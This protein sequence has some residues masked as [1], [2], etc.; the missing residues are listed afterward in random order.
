MIQTEAAG[1]AEVYVDPPLVLE[2]AQRLHWASDDLVLA[3]IRIDDACA[4]AHVA[5]VGGDRLQRVAA[6]AGES[7]LEMRRRIEHYLASVGRD[8]C[9]AG[10]VPLPAVGPS[11]AT[12]GLSDAVPHPTPGVA[13][14]PPGGPDA[15]S[16]VE[17]VDYRSDC[18]VVDHGDEALA[19]LGMIP[20]VGS[21]FDAG[22][23]VAKLVQGKW[24]DA[25]LYLAA[26]VPGPGDI[27]DL[28]LKESEQERLAALEDRL[29][30]AS[31][32]PDEAYDVL[33]FIESHNGTPPR[34]YAGGGAWRNDLG[35]LP[36]GDYRKYD[37]DV[38]VD[39]VNRSG[40]RLLV[41]NASDAVW[42]G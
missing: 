9:S 36:T 14:A 18:G 20:V 2:L 5:G 42:Y 8:H 12:R 1:S 11:R 26:A 3:G 22:H 23:S 16:A 7:G 39:G 15:A 34:D 4:S 35:Q 27:E 10:V 25:A 6:L 19:Y 33:T 30:Q 24:G 32:I 41:D 40:R 28:V 31:N 37:I 21:F 38:N 17:H 29:A 13:P